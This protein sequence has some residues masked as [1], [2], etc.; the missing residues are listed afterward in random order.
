MMGIKVE[1]GE[2]RREILE[3][4]KKIEKEEGKNNGGLDVKGKKDEMEIR[5][6]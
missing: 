4:K 5:R 3:K 6:N 2:K 1:G